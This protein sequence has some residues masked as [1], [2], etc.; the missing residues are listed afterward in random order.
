MTF[1]EYWKENGH[2]H[3]Y[4]SDGCTKCCHA[5]WL[6]AHAEG[7]R[8][9]RERLTPYLAQCRH[10]GIPLPPSGGKEGG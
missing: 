8:E 10:D 2:D 1:E 5:T 7:V 3:H 9:E 6:V 4:R